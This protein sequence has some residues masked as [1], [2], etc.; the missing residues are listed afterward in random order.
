LTHDSIVFLF[1]ARRKETWR[2]IRPWVLVLVPAFAIPFLMFGFGHKRLE[3]LWELNLFFG[4]FLVLL[5][6]M[7]RISFAVAKHYRCPACD[8][9]PS[10]L[11]RGVPVDPIVCP[12]CG[13]RLK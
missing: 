12:N 3:A 9:M 2:I 4:D 8:R 10:V 7:G 5:I 1:Q 13:V 11:N 6:T